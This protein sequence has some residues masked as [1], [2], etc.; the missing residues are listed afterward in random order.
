VGAAAAAA[1]TGGRGVAV[2]GSVAKP[3]AAAAA[4]EPNAAAAAGACTDAGPETNAGLEHP[5]DANAPTVQLERAA[6]RQRT[7][8]KHFV[9]FINLLLHFFFLV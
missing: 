2:A 3:N 7:K 9:V 6:K 8:V 4:K 1:A 5:A